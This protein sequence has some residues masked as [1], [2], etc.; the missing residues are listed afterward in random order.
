LY[1]V[2][3]TIDKINVL[4]EMVFDDIN[5]DEPSEPLVMVEKERFAKHPENCGDKLKVS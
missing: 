2:L 4:V 3:K 5:D 1:V